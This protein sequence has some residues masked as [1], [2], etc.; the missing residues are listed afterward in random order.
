MQAYFERFTITMTKEQAKNAS[1]QGA[2]DLD[3][4]EL[5]ELPKIK[6]QMKKINPAD[7]AAE[8]KDYGAWDETELA[9]YDANIQRIL[10]IAAGNIREENN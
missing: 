1:H 2:C 6:R 8:L 5:S 4:K 3:V 9:D 7:I 10:W